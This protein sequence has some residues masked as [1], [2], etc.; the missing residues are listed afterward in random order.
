MQQQQNAS[1]TANNAGT[2]LIINYLPQDMTERELH[3]IFS[4]MGPVESCRVM[5][6]FKVRSLL[7]LL[8]LGKIC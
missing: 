7:D 2:N 6:D 1:Q 3:S 8:L 4:T 5:R